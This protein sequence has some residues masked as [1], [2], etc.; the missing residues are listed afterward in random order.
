MA[1]TSTV[2]ALKAALKT[3]IAAQA[4]SVQVVRHWPG[5]ATE[6][7]GVYIGDVKGVSE[8]D[9]I[10]TGR[11]HRKERYT[12]TIVVQTFYAGATSADADDSEDRAYA[13][14]AFVENAVAADADVGAS[15]KWSEIVGWEAETVK[16]QNGWATRI[17]I[18]LS[19]TSHLT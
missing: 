5:P 2:P 10:K 9:S 18:E 7:E 15:V 3:A 19:C 13:L 8:I 14:M 1:T 4:G 17:E 6:A 11:Q 12:V 16:F